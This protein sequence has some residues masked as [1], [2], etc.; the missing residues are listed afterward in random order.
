[1]RSH[2]EL[3]AHRACLP[4]ALLCGLL[5]CRTAA[6]GSAAAPGDPAASAQNTQGPGSGRFT[7]VVQADAPTRRTASE[8][9][10]DAKTLSV[11][12]LRSGDDLLRVVPGLLIS[13]H[14]AEGKGTQ[15]FLRGFDAAHG[16]DVEVTVDDLPVNE[17]SNVHGQGYLD[18]G[19]LIPEAVRSVRTLKSPFQ[20]SQ[21]PLAT[22]GSVR[23]QLGVPRE[24]RGV[25]ASYQIG[26]TNR[27]RVLLVAAPKKLSEDTFLAIEGMSD[28]GYGQ[29]RHSERA[30][31]LGKIR[32]WSDGDR[33]RL[34]ALVSG[35][36]ARF[37][38]PSPVPAADYAEGRI[39]FYD[40][41]SQGTTGQSSRALIGL[42]FTMQRAHDHLDIWSHAQW[43]RLDLRENF[44]GYLLD[45]EHGDARE[46]Y[47]RSLGAGL[48]LRYTRQLPIGLALFGGADWQSES[49]S[50]YE[51]QID[52]AGQAWR[53]NRD[54]DA[55]Q[56][57]GAVHL[58][59]R[60]QRFTWLR[61]EGGLRLDVFHM[62]ARE[63]LDRR[64]GAA[65][66]TH[67]APRLNAAFLLPRGASLFAAYGR[68]VRPPEARSVLTTGTIE[69]KQLGEYQGRA[70]GLTSTDSVEF[71]ARYAPRSFLQLG[72]A[73]FGTWIDQEVLFDHVAAVSVGLNSTRRL[74]VELE[75]QANPLSWLE[76]RL[77][78]TYVDARF[79]D[80]Q[81]PV[82]GAPRFLAVLSGTLTHPSG[83]RAGLRLLGLAPRPLQYGAMSA[84]A[85][86]LDLVAGYRWRA[87]Q[88]DLQLDNALNQTWR[89]GE[90]H[91]PS[92][93]DTQRPRSALPALHF[94]AGPPLTLRS[95]L[96]V[97]L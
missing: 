36:A 71:G 57:I 19:F 47:H 84:G 42:R 18:L 72:L 37:G 3:M 9:T 10:V 15:I 13:R 54:T 45:R 59:A 77:D 7:A 88:L 49:I 93:F 78:A 25:R 30:S 80:S 79:V 12:P 69:Q 95:S 53:R 4:A 32:L 22:A 46:Q 48:H 63:R 8:R 75:V 94:A 21:G 35:Y 83:F 2:K 14:G 82:P 41:Y 23:V 17:I 92:W 34:V 51:D 44:T 61:L 6:A 40:S 97:W 43:R 73:G 56:H 5:L 96:T 26:T 27:H 91:Y 60:L 64:E 86:V 67:L 87:L 11:T 50:Q 68:G 81:G 29:N 28:S 66:L 20:L 52:H 24:L 1:M 31:L 58:G 70:V 39:G 38:E 65:T 89:E 85:A 33:M 62:D 74:G 90:F 55:D 76:L 16:S